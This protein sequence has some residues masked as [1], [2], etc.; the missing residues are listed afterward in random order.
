MKTKETSTPPEVVATKD[1]PT[2]IQRVTHDWYVTLSREIK[3]PY[4]NQQY[5]SNWVSIT[6]SRPTL[7][8]AIAELQVAQAHF[9]KELNLPPT[10]QE[11]KE[12]ETLKERIEKQNIFIAMMKEH[13][14]IWSL[15]TKELQ[16]FNK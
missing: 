13:P 12:I 1:L 2:S 14:V 16:S 3:V 11:I 7:E 9:T 10:P 6:V 5:T 4:N 8:E 15:F